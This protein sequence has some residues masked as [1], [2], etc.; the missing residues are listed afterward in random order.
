[1]KQVHWQHQNHSIHYGGAGLDMLASHMMGFRQEF[2]G[3]FQFDDVALSQSAE[4]LPQ[5]LAVHIFERR[6]PLQI[7]E[8][9]ASTCNTSPGTS[10]MYKQALEQLSGDQDIVVRSEEGVTRK[11]AKYMRD[12][13]WVERSPQAALFSLPRGAE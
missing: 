10:I 2:T 11:H 9:Y 7:G 13:D 3:G 12:T 4:V 6:Q 1:M 8:L 5:Q